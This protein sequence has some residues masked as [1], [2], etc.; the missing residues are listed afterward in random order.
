MP[1]APATSTLAR[2]TM[3]SAFEDLNR[4]ITPADSRSFHSITLQ[5]VR[6]EAIQIEDELAARQCLRNMRRLTPLFTG[7]EHYAKVMDVLCNG[8]PYLP[9]IWAPVTLI[10]RVASEYVEAFEQIIKGYARIAE[11]L[12]RFQILQNAF[13]NSSDFQV[14]LAAFYADILHFHRHGYKFVRRN[15]WKLLFLTSW[16]R[17][18]RRFD[19]ILD[20]M[21]RHETL[22]D[23][24]A[25]ARDI[26]EARQMRQDIRNW[27]EEGIGR[28]KVFEEEQ[29]SK[30]YQAV[31]S[32]MKL[33]ES[34]R[35]AIF[36]AISAEGTK[37]PGTCEWVLK[38]PKIQSWLQSKPDVPILWLQGT[39]GSGKS[40]ISTQLV[41]F[42]ESAGSFV[43]HH[44]CTYAYASSKKYV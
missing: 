40:V 41:N 3:K 33:D 36:D 9:W 18:Q 31:A 15:G 25:N 14:T 4:T 44:F 29:A 28:V 10:L 27:R 16:G 37:H 11:S 1:L 26:T 42:I 8:T 5:D 7:L 13:D 20:D 22:I 43:I 34:D 17:F 12:E 19:N 6:R 38:H 24:G 35:L 23:L 2:Q 39:P 21:K 32:W 30:Q